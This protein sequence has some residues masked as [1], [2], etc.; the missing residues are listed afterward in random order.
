M[1]DINRIKSLYDTFSQAGPAVQ[2]VPHA[3]S[4]TSEVPGPHVVFGLM[5]HGNETG[6]LPAAITLARA[7]ASGTQRFTGTV[8]L[9]IGNPA[10]GLA[11]ERF[12]EADLN[13]VFIDC[14]DDTIEH[15]RARLLRHILD[16]A[17]LF[18]DFHQTIEPTSSP[19]YI[20]PWSPQAEA[21]VR[22]LKAAP[23]WVT[24]APGQTFSAGTCCADEY[25]RNRDRPALTIE[26]SQQ[27]FHEH[28][29]ALALR[30]MQ[31]T[32]ALSSGTIPRQGQLPECLET[33]FFQRF[34]DPGMCLR[35]GLSNFQPVSS[36]EIL[37]APGTPQLVCPIDG[38]LMFPKYPR[39]DMAGMAVDPRPGELYRVLQPIPGLP[40]DQYRS[41]AP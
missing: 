31:R 23:R 26:L 7:L 34:T 4:F 12:L 30:T 33:T 37:S 29:E 22:A 36:G 21:W 17:D 24:R 3:I 1:P 16:T 2:G 5:V 13:R 28:A 19:F 27:G 39:R 10:A 6:A 15:R 14:N 40:A 8:S 25:V 18:I 35:V 38:L 11:G 41:G 20:L 9:F 32:L